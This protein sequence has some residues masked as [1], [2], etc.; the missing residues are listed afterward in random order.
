MRSIG[1]FDFGLHYW[2]M[3]SELT[4]AR[5]DSEQIRLQLYHL[6]DRAEIEWREE[7]VRIADHWTKGKGDKS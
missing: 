1:A 7:A 4:S 3:F 6:V 2:S 5:G